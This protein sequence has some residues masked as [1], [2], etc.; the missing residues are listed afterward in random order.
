M[1]R[2]SLN[3]GEGVQTLLYEVSQKRAQM[4]LMSVELAAHSSKLEAQSYPGPKGMEL[5]DRSSVSPGVEGVGAQSSVS[6]GVEGVG[7][8]SHPGLKG[9]KC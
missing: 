9:C 5:R 3:S 7:A 4:T 2:V 1:T 8:Q 6:P